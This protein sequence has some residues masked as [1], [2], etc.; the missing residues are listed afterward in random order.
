MKFDLDNYLA[1]RINPYQREKRAYRL[2]DGTVIK[3]STFNPNRGQEQSVGQVVTFMEADVI[4]HSDRFVE[5]YKPVVLKN[6]NEEAERFE[7]LVDPRTQVYQGI[8]KEI[9][10]LDGV[11]DENTP[12][13]VINYTFASEMLTSTTIAWLFKT[14][15]ELKKAIEGLK[16][17]TTTGDVAGC[18]FPD[19]SEAHPLW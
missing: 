8:I 4:E 2:E 9:I 6:L 10:E 14:I 7:N 11:I 17:V 13:E 12:E 18:D 16:S 3:F 5:V 1:D 15:F 19:R